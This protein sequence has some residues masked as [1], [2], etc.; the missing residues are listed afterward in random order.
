MRQRQFITGLG[1]AAAWSLALRAQQSERTR[2][3]GVLMVVDD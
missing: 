1:S 3:I 2:R